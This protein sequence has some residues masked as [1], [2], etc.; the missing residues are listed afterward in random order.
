MTIGYG[1]TLRN[2]R[3]NAVTT[4]VNASGQATLEMFSGTRPSFGGTAGALLVT[5]NMN[6]TPFGASVAGKITANTI[7]PEEAVAD[8]TAQWFRIS[9]G[10]GTAIIDG[11]IGLV[12]S[13][14]DIEM[15]SVTVS[16][17]LIVALSSLSITE[18]N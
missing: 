5:L 12:G 3:M 2:N 11:D 17:G 10:S 7:E 13:G 6:T 18:G 4:A 8:G 16:T 15:T 14:A 9:T 1:T